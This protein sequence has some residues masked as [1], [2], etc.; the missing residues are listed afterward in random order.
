MAAGLP[1][2]ASDFPLYR[3]FVK[4]ARCGLLVD[5]T[6]PEEIGTAIQWLLDHPDEAKAM[7]Q[8]GRQA[9]LEKYNWDNEAVKLLSFYEDLLQG[10]ELPLHRARPVSETRGPL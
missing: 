6:S 10:E 1:V 9:V 5:P 4:D 2:V 8:R 7:G 3:Q